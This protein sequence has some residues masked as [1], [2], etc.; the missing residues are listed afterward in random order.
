MQENPDKLHVPCRPIKI[1]THLGK[2]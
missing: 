2:R 1:T